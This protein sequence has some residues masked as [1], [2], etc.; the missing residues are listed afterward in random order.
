M[1]ELL[2]MSDE[3]LS[4]VPDFTIFNDFGSIQFLGETDLRD[5]DL[6]DVVT[7]ANKEVEVYNE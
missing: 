1:N 6:A 4:G 3:E 2:K 7:I 5:V